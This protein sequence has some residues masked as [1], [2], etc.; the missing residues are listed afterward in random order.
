MAVRLDHTAA[1]ASCPVGEGARLGFQLPPRLTV[2]QWADGNRFIARGTGPEPGRWRTDRL[3]LLRQVM[4]AV[5]DAAVHTV[6]LKCS[7][8]AAKT[9]VLINVAAFFVDQ[10]PAPQMF[11]LPTL[12][13]ADSFSTKRIDPTIDATPALA[14][15][16]GSHKSRDASTTIREKSY[17]GGDI[18]LRQLA[19][20]PRLA[21]APHRHLRRDRQVQG[22]HRPRRRSDPPGPAARTELLEPPRAARLDADADQAVGHRRLVPALRP[23]PPLR[24]V[25][26]LRRVSAARMG[27]GRG[28]CQAAPRRVDEGQA[29]H[30]PLYLSALRLDLGPARPD[31]RGSPRPVARARRLQGYRRLPL[32]ERLHALGDAG[33]ARRRVGGCGRQAREGAD[34]RQPEA[35]PQLR[36]VENHSDHGRD[37]DGATRGLRPSRRWLQAAARGARRHRLR[38]RAG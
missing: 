2:S 14:A 16:L 28:R 1:G 24:A 11:V 35:G 34:L 5:N 8:Q 32:V 13:L 19:R 26:G 22:E 4:D 7:S 37:A 33:S 27:D 3:P 21:P 23:A 20:E 36:S 15:K 17:P 25:Q 10:D 38:R 9:E 30:R 18:V 12:E 6:V 29:R 31:A